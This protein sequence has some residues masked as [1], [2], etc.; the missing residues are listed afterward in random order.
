MIKCTNFLRKYVTSTPLFH[1]KLNFS[2]KKAKKRHKKAPE[3]SILMVRETLYRSLPHAT[4]LTHK[5]RKPR[6]RNCINQ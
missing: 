4:A 1:E 3:D 6:V 2:R 5:P